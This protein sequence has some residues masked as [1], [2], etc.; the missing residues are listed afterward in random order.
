MGW[1]LGWLIFGLLAAYESGGL[2]MNA[3]GD[4]GPIRAIAFLVA[5]ATGLGV[6]LWR[7]VA[8]GRPAKLRAVWI[9]SIVALAACL[10]RLYGSNASGWVTI[11]LF[12]IVY[13]LL[14]L[15]AGAVGTVMA[16]RR[17]RAHGARVAHEMS[18]R[19]RHRR[20]D[21]L[22]ADMAPPAAAMAGSDQ[23]LLG[24]DSDFTLPA[25]PKWEES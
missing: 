11:A 13:S 10:W 9:L 6:I 19:A 3:G 7:A 15:L 8:S 5:S 25:R 1:L 4:W 18:E 2:A 12:G 21:S 22:R 16:W 17:H 14:C 24:P 20:M 23:D